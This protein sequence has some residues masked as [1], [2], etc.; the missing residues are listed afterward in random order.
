MKTPAR[1]RLQQTRDVGYF[2]FFWELSKPSIYLTFG[3]V[4]AET[5][6]APP[7]HGG[8][9]CKFIPPSPSRI[10]ECSGVVEA[11]GYASEHGGGLSKLLYL[12]TSRL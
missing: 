4:C 6:A 1:D 10:D 3:R 11:E 9:C 8:L 5:A 2:F 12:P 7:L